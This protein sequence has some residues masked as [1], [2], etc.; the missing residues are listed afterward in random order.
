[1]RMG[2]KAFIVATDAEMSSIFSTLPHEKGIEV[3]KCFCES[4]AL[5]R[6]RKRRP[7]CLSCQTSTTSV[8][9][10]P[11]RPLAEEHRIEYIC[12]HASHQYIA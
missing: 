12:P 9:F 4:S 5:E 6:A 8:A 2:M 11:L 10:C 3:E 1:M 7:R